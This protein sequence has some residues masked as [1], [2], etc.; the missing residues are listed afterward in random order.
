MVKGFWTLQVDDLGLE[1][2]MSARIRKIFE[3]LQPEVVESIRLATLAMLDS[4]Q[5][6]MTLDA[7][8]GPSNSITGCPLQLRSVPGRTARRSAYDPRPRS[9]SGSRG[10]AI[11]GDGEIWTGWPTL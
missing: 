8:S 10:D 6:V 9:E 1:D 3:G 7:P 2:D 11:G 5:Y 4:D